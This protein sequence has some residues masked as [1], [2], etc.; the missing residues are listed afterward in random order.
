MN[1][2]ARVPARYRGGWC[3]GGPAGATGAGR[4][5]SSRAG[6]MNQQTRGP[7]DGPGGAFAYPGVSRRAHGRWLVEMVKGVVG[8]CRPGNGAAGSGGFSR[9]TGTGECSRVVGEIRR[10]ARKGGGG[11]RYVRGL[12]RVV[13]RA[14]ANL[15]TCREV[16]ESAGCGGFLVYPG[17]S[18]EGVASAGGGCW[19]GRCWVV[20]G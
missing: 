19:C 5:R 20:A 15:P 17:V 2:R 8:G 6:P 1:A 13:R 12:P 3:S 9:A 16:G 7:A 14:L 11:E 18:E 10:R 4:C